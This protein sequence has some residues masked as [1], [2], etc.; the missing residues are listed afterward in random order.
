[1][2]ACREIPEQLFPQ[3]QVHRI[4]AEA[5][6][7]D[8]QTTDYCTIRSCIY[9]HKLVLNLHSMCAA[10][11]GK[12]PLLFWFLTYFVHLPSFLRSP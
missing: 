7:T 3:V 12:T 4:S 5:L 1:V 10:H 2:V 9:G 6:Q 11:L 8:M